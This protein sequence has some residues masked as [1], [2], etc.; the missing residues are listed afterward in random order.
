M[1]QAQGLTETPHGSLGTVHN[2][3]VPV[4]TQELPSGVTMSVMV[5]GS[6]VVTGGSVGR[7]GV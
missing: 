3:V 2:S 5:A 6:A 1:D 7:G 4:F